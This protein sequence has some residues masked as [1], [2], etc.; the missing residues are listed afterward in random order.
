MITSY[1]VGITILIVCVLLTVIV[2][3]IVAFIEAIKNVINYGDFS[4]LFALLL[5]TAALVGLGL[6]IF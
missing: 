6:V 1:I 2:F 3:Y 4:G 5:L